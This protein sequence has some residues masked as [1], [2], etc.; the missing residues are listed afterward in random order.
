ME[1]TCNQCAFP[2]QDPKSAEYSTGATPLMHAAGKGYLQC[3][4]E[5]IAAGADVNQADDDGDTPLMWAAM[6]GQT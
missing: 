6:G 4:K 2:I 1:G 3:V 5:L